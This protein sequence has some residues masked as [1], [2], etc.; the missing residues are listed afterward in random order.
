MDGFLHTVYSGILYQNNG[1]SLTQFKLLCQCVIFWV[2]AGFTRCNAYSNVQCISTAHRQISNYNTDIPLSELIPCHYLL[3]VSLLTHYLTIS[4]FVHVTNVQ[5]WSHFSI[6]CPT[7]FA[8]VCLVSRCTG[9]LLKKVCHM[10][11]RFLL[12]IK[13]LRGGKLW[14]EQRQKGR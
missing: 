10:C 5:N 12:C 6:C 13:R 1:Q 14:S 8:S 11:E 2:C 7:A 3:P 4:L 9:L